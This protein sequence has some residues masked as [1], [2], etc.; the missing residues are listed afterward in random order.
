MVLS[1]L[2]YF[3]FVHLNLVFTHDNLAVSDVSYYNPNKAE[4][5]TERFHFEWYLFAS[6]ALRIALPV[7]P[8]FTMANLLIDGPSSMI[9]Y[10]III[11][12]L[13]AVEAVK[14]F[15]YSYNLVFCE[16]FQFCRNFDPSGDS[17][18][19]NIVFIV[20]YAYTF[21][22]TLFCALYAFLGSHI[23]KGRKLQERRL[24]WMNYRNNGGWAANP[25]LPMANNL[26]QL[27][28]QQQQQ[29]PPPQQNHYQPIPVYPQEEEYSVRH[30]DPQISRVDETAGMVVKALNY[31]KENRERNSNYDEESGGSSSES[32]Y[33]VVVKQSDSSHS[34]LL[35]YVI[36]SSSSS[37]QQKKKK[38]SNN[39]K[40]IVKFSGTKQK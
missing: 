15:K 25:F 29:P 14:L 24:Q 17:N 28:A 23:N 20:M 31:V 34:K 33:E 26:Q 12:I 16:D 30:K 35:K 37:K 19:P 11:F 7:L 10:T 5:T 32:E 2:V 13:L 6:D 38:T 40:N 8:L 18:K 22:F 9:W 36:P 39:I 4:S 21:A 27:Q 3:P 1:L